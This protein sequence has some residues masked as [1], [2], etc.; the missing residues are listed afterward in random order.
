MVFAPTLRKDQ[1][2]SDIVTPEEAQRLALQAKVE[3]CF[4]LIDYATLWEENFIKS[5][6]HQIKHKMLSL[7]QATIVLELLPK[8]VERSDDVN[9]R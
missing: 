2:M 5:V 9:G 1:A 6:R 7:K 8:L 4:T 3:D